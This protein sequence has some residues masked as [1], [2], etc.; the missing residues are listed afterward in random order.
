M[1]TATN[2]RLET[3]QAEMVNE[4]MCRDPIYQAEAIAKHYLSHVVIAKELMAL[5]NLRERNRQSSAVDMDSVD[6]L[7]QRLVD[8]IKRNHLYSLG[9][10]LDWSPRNWGGE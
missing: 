10:K 5:L 8:E 9:I 6:Q 4:A 2:I 3:A 7:I 1:K